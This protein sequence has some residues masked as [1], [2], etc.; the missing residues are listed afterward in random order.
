MRT[1]VHPTHL[2]HEVVLCD[3]LND[4]GGV[5]RVDDHGVNLLVVRALNGPRQIALLV[6]IVPVVLPHFHNVHLNILGKKN[7]SN[8]NNSD[9][10]WTSGSIDGGENI[11]INS[12]SKFSLTRFSGRFE[13]LALNC[14]GSELA[15]VICFVVGRSLPDGK[16]YF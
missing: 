8:C 2:E 7:K 4:F 10:S 13:V 5:I 6:H 15:A 1:T 14:H 12:Q 3:G 11:G 16:L 9:S